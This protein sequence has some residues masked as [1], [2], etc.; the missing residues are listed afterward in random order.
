[1][2]KRVL[3]VLMLFVLVSVGMIAIRQGAHDPIPVEIMKPSFFDKPEEIG[4]VVYRR[5]YAPIE[6]AK[7]VVIGIPPEPEFN[8]A[9]IRGFLQAANAEKRPFEAL[10]SEERMSPIDLVGVPPLEA[11]TMMVNTET[12]TEF[13]DK[14]KALKDAGKRTLVYV[15]SVFST[16]FL[17]GNP[18]LRYE[19]ATKQSL[20][21]I[22]VGPLALRQDQEYIV[23]PSC[24]GSQVDGMGLAPLGCEI[25]RASRQLYRKHVPQDRYVAYMNSMQPNDYLLLISYPGQAQAEP[26]KPTPPAKPPSL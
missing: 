4:A 5:F 3:Y 20:F 7:V 6:E 13:V 25:M 26:P 2:G 15:P 24:I 1:M 19:A 12:Q 23:S 8:R 21:T 11:Q 22:T 16:H 10:I 17:P 18:V 14:L 9:I